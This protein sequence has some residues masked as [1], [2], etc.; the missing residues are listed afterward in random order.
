MLTYFIWKGKYT[1]EDV[2]ENQ[3]RY[4]KLLDA[5]L[6][7]SG[8]EP[9]L[10]EEESAELLFTALIGYCNE[11]I[12]AYFPNSLAG[13]IH[14]GFDRDELTRLGISAKEALDHI[15]YILRNSYRLY[16]LFDNTE[17]EKGLSF[18]TCNRALFLFPD[19]FIGVLFQYS[20]DYREQKYYRYLLAPSFELVDDGEEYWE[21]WS[22]WSGR[23][24]D[25]RPDRD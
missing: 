17:D 16:N 14:L 19:G 15:V 4:Y 12:C 6:E 21:N 3:T 20:P 22:D 8:R 9:G 2:K 18:I 7:D 11:R 5:L 1:M 23:L 24:D 13:S 25:K 10:T